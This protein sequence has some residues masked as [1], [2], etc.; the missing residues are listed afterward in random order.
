MSRQA[1]SLAQLAAVILAPLVH[2]AVEAMQPAPVPKSHQEQPALLAQVLHDVC[3]A[4]DV[5]GVTVPEIGPQTPVAV[6]M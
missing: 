2:V 3:R 6:Q 4:Q 1:R 5:H